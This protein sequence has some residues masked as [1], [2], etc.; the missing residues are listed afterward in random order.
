MFQLSKLFKYIP[1][2][3]NIN[4]FMKMTNTNT[5][6][7]INTKTKELVTITDQA[8]LYISNLLKPDNYL[9]IKVVRGGCNG[10]N[11]D[12]QIASLNNLSKSINDCQIDL[13][14]NTIREA[15]PRYD[16][17][18]AGC[19]WGKDKVGNMGYLLFKQ[20]AEAMSSSTVEYPISIR[21]RW[22]NQ[23]CEAKVTLV[24]DALTETLFTMPP[25]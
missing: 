8:K 12:F 16:I 10:L 7:N 15:H 21:F 4:Q 13:L 9:N 19:K 18:I 1:I 5:N 3:Y 2:N 22:K 20:D 25:E 17:Y 11:Y 24:Y 23:R 6:T 14:D